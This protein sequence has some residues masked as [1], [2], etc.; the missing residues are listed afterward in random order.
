[1]LRRT[2]LAGIAMAALAPAGIAAADDMAWFP[3]EPPTSAAAGECYARVRVEAEYR[4]YT[5]TI[6]TG[7]TYETYNVRPAELGYDVREFISREAGMRYIV[8][9]PVYDV[10]TEQV[11]VRPAYV[12]YRVIP[13]VHEEVTERIMVREPRMVW[14]RGRVPG[15]QMTRYDAETGEIWCLVEEAGEYRT[16]TRNVLVTPARVD[17]VQYEAEYATIQREVLVQEA[18]V[19]EVPIPAEYDQVE[20]QTLVRAASVDSQTVQGRTDTV[21]RYELVAEERYEWR[22]MDCDEMELPGY[23]PPAS[24]RQDP[25]AMSYQYQGGGDYQE[26]QYD[27]TETPVASLAS[28]RITH[29]GGP[30][31]IQAAARQ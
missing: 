2:Y 6:V 23:V 26:P 10:I 11:M 3:S 13:A 25:P 9:E 30:R 18:R 21:T 28:S 15:A 22:L 31:I 5:E 14:Q 24:M 1:M 27:E 20:I 7:D 29:V 8:H 16:V 19:E 12:E 17:E 4:P